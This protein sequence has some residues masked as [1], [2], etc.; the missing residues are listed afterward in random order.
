MQKLL[1]FC[2][3]ILVSTS[4][5]SQDYLDVL[6]VTYNGATLGNVDTE[7]ETEVDNTFVEFYFPLPVTSDISIIGGFTYENTRLGLNFSPSRTNLIMTRL[8]LGIK[9]DH[10]NKWS[11][12]YVALPKLASDFNQGAGD[13]FQMG[14]LALLEKRYSSKYS[15]KFGAY[16]SSENFGTTITPLI[17]LWY[18][19]KDKKFTINATLPIR[20]DVNYAI[21]DNFSLGANLVTSIK[22]YNLSA[23]ESRL[24]VQEESI[25]FSLF[26]AYAFLDNTLVARAKIGLD[27][28]DYGL[29]RQGDKVGAQLLTFQLGGDDRDRLN[30]EFDSSVFYGIDFIYRLG[31]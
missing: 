10:G 20:T 22:S 31:L 14:G 16:V 21:T 25:R 24:Y 11:G 13:N 28:T 15:F 4:L 27:T 12:T 18:K 6:K 1:L 17:G 5:Y 19:S 9:Y 30:N 7:V 29:Y 8:N 3:I 2:V 26:G 23:T